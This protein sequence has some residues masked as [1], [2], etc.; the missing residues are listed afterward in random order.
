MLQQGVRLLN[1]SKVS[2]N[3]IEALTFEI[4]AFRQERFLAHNFR[5]LLKFLN[6]AFTL[7]ALSKNPHECS[8]HFAQYL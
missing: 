6:L 4:R 5:T 8:R 3:S 1:S 7:F 2:N